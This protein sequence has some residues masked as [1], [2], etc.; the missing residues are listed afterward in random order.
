MHVSIV[1]TLETA[2]NPAC[3]SYGGLL[4]Q[5]VATFAGAFRYVC[6][7]IPLRLLAAQTTFAGAWNMASARSRGRFDFLDYPFW[8]PKCLPFL[9]AHFDKND[10]NL[11]SEPLQLSQV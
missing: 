6:W 1:Y 7:R 5:Q 4:T 9:V 8:V 3:R 2:V 11:R 10:C